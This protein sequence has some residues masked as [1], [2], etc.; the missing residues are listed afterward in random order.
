MSH[1][2]QI[3]RSKFVSSSLNEIKPLLALFNQ[4]QIISLTWVLKTA[5]DIRLYVSVF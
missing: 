2:W 1:G 3:N 5:I 4:N